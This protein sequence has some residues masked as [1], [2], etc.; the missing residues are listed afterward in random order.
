MTNADLTEA[1]ADQRPTPIEQPVQQRQILAPMTPVS[2]PS[3]QAQHG[4][5]SSLPPTS[6]QRQSSLPPTLPEPL[7][8]E[9]L[10]LDGSGWRA[11]P[12]LLGPLEPHPSDQLL[13]LNGSAYV[14]LNALPAHPSPIPISQLTGPGACPL[15]RCIPR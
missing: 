1:F 10:W 13:R 3:R 9:E 15:L 7:D 2:S 4:R 8:E 6:P 14:F 11:G 5:N 12:R